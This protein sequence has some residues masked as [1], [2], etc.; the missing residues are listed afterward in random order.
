MSVDTL[1]HVDVCKYCPYHTEC[2]LSMGFL[3]EIEKTVLMLDK[4]EYLFRQGDVFDG[5][6][7]FCQ[8]GAK[9]TISGPTPSSSVVEFYHPSDLIG[10]CGFDNERYQESVRVMTYSRVLK[11]DKAHFNSA[12]ANTPA[13]A[14]TMFSLLSERLVA[15][16]HR[17]AAV[18][19]LEAESRL[20]QFLYEQYKWSNPGKTTFE[21]PMP[22]SDIASYLGIAVETL[23]RLMK[24]L[25]QKGFIQIHNRTIAVKSPDQNSQSYAV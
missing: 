18:T 25:A 21:L 9:A 11:I 1:C 15:R 22:R 24:A 17:Y 23:S 10:L 13:L 16:Q 8:G 2:K 19:S 4:G 20:K 3:K 7:I 5:F 14:T 12:L 6:Y